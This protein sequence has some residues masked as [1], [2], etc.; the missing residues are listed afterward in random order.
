MRPHIK[1]AQYSHQCGPLNVWTWGKKK[2]KQK[3]KKIH[4]GWLADIL[5]KGG[6]DQGFLSQKILIILDLIMYI[7]HGGKMSET[8]NSKRQ[9]YTGK[10]DLALK[11]KCSFQP[12]GNSE[13]RNEIASKAFYSMWVSSVWIQQKS[14]WEESVEK[15]SPPF[16]SAHYLFWNSYLRIGK[17]H[18]QN[19]PQDGSWLVWDGICSTST[20]VGEGIESDFNLISPCCGSTLSYD[21]FC[22][23]SSLDSEDKQQAAWGKWRRGKRHFGNS[24]HKLF[25][26]KEECRGERELLRTNDISE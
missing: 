14:P 8:T 25:C 22:S 1:L 2:Q 7:S 5:S 4:K 11:R 24:F 10:I 19:V 3:L 21:D 6:N 13:Q 23:Q 15:I 9:I 16:Q 17:P 12:V 18:T 26:W 20:S